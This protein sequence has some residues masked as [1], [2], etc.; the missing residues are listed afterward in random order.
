MKASIVIA[1]YRRG[2]LLVKCLEALARQSFN[3]EDFEIIIV[4]DGIDD[5]ASALVKNFELANNALNVVFYCLP[6][7]R[8]P[9]AA[10]NTGWKLAS[11][12]L[13]LFTDDDCL[14][15]ETWIADCWND[16]MSVGLTMAAFTGKIKVPLPA[17]PTDYERNTA[18]LETAEFVT[19]NCA[20]TRNALEL[21]NGFDEDFK[22]AW[23]EDS[24]LQFRLIEAGVPVLKTNAMVTHPV[25]SAE[26]GAS[27]REQKKSMFNALLYKKHPQLYKQKITGTGLWNYY[28]IIIAFLTA[29]TALVQK[30]Y[31]LFNI[32]L[33]L[34]MGA[35]F[36]FLF[37]RLK[38]TSRQPGHLFE[39]FVTSLLIPFISVYWNWYGALK[40]KKLP[41]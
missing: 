31:T 14:P 15:S 33:L 12:Q 11:G 32:A 22:M 35:T 7:N 28:L 36:Y 1:T 24:D 19:A 38:N 10:R 5:Q 17:F 6:V 41:L 2:K 18:N 29:I 9:A 8:G 26:W 39:M 23:R 16:Y 25:R 40:F 27:I 20:C 3:K 13:I 4:S 34:W 37:K 21:V 30:Q